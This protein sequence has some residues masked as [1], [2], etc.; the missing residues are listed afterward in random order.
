M[1][2]VDTSEMVKTVVSHIISMA[3]SLGMTV[4]GEG[5][6]TEAQLRVLQS[7]GCNQIQGYLLGKPLS[8]ENMA[9]LI[10]EQQ[11]VLNGAVSARDE[12]AYG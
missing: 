7:L 3:H 11:I 12:L 5:V 6:E 4:V 10:L 2:G 8:R 1:E 9:A